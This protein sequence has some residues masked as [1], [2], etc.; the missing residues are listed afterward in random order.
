MD[1]KQTRDGE[2][3]LA[4]SGDILFVQDAARSGHSRK[5]TPGQGRG[6]PVMMIG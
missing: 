5:V 6:T 1:R 3:F 2:H 4:R